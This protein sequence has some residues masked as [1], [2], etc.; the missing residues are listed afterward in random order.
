MAAVMLGGGHTSDT[1]MK[2]KTGNKFKTVGSYN[3][4][5]GILKGWHL[6]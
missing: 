4:Y 6:K 5:P 2:F 1:K 3:F